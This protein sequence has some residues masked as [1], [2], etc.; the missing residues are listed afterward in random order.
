MVKLWENDISPEPMPL[1]GDVGSGL[2]KM[3][4]MTKPYIS[5]I[6]YLELCTPQCLEIH[7]SQLCFYLPKALISCLWKGK[8][9]QNHHCSFVKLH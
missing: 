1:I 2:K 5:Q 3:K 4:T 8:N 9:T 6:L 7:F